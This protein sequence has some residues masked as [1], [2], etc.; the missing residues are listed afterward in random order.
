MVQQP[1]QYVS[2]HFKMTDKKW[3]MAMTNFVIDLASS[4]NN[5]SETQKYLDAANG[6]VDKDTYKYVLATYN[7]EQ[8]KKEL[9]PGSIRDVDFL[10]PIKDRYMGEFI[11]AYHNYQVFSNDPDVVFKR[12]AKIGAKVYEM[13]MQQL[14][15]ELNAQGTDTGKESKEVPD[16]ENG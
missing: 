16:I 12:N 1:D 10:K 5:K 6:I 11:S 3:G 15:N 8:G 4:F 9:M 14:V 2:S 13:L 7:S